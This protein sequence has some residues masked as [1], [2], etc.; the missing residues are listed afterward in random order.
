MLLPAE[1]ESRT[2]VLHELKFGLGCQF[3]FRVPFS[4]NIWQVDD[5][6]SCC[7][8][9]SDRTHRVLDYK[10]GN[11][12]HRPIRMK[13][14]D[15]NIWPLLMKG[16]LNRWRNSWPVNPIKELFCFIGRFHNLLNSSTYWRTFLILARTYGRCVHRVTVPIS[17]LNV[18]LL[19]NTF[20]PQAA[21]VEIEHF[22]NSTR[23]FK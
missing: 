23:S 7:K 4:V 3:F 21:V 8:R 15:T 11:S 10:K 1:K 2:L 14:V 13:R 20:R 5:C 18:V 9:A 19:A 22:A 6:L 17:P 16:C 12:D